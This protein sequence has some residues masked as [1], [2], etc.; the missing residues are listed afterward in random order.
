[1]VIKSNKS[2]YNLKCPQCGW[3]KTSWIN[4]PIQLCGLKIPVVSSLIENTQLPSKCPECGHKLN[5]E[6]L[7]VV[8]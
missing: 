4:N 7:P 6:Q 5:K 8:F 1:M 3:E 2:L